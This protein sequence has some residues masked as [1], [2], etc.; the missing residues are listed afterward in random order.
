M[1]NDTIR[2][3]LYPF[4]FLSS[5][6]FG[7]RFFVQ[8]LQSEKQ[9]TSVTPK[10][11]WKLSVTGNVLLLIHSIIQVHFPMSLCQAVNAVLGAR[12]LNL[13]QK[14]RKPLSFRTTL[15]ILSASAVL[16]SILFFLQG[17][18]ILPPSLYLS[19]MR[20]ECAPWMHS[21]GS[22]GILC[23]SM[24]FWIQWWY[25]EQSMQSTLPEIFWWLSLIGSFLSLCYFYYLGDIVNV[26]GPLV[27]FVP[28]S[29]NLW[30]L[31]KKRYAS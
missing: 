13:I 16:V 29:R 4:G 19:A 28:Y 25:V 8:W 11:F 10:A 15:F 17:A 27:S 12:N 24:R 6:A 23:Y 20:P 1:M 30:L 14:K 26:I 5:I 2:E 21:I 3:L 18:W 31:Y 7:L 9:G 22:I